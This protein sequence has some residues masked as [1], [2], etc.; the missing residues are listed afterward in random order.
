[1]K[2]VVR[3]YIPEPLARGYKT[4]NEFQFRSYIFWMHPSF[5]KCLDSQLFVRLSN[6]FGVPHYFNLQNTKSQYQSTNLECFKVILG[7]SQGRINDLQLLIQTV[8]LLFEGLIIFLLLLKF[9]F[10]IQSLLPELAGVVVE[11]LV[12]AGGTDVK[13]ISA[14]LVWF[15]LVFVPVWIVVA[16]FI[17]VLVRFCNRV[18]SPLFVR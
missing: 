7:I 12:A 18:N 1:M 8:Q 2:R 5:L 17:A 3:F 4:R 6:F 16:I 15:L 14:F 10:D 13:V 9:L 11:I